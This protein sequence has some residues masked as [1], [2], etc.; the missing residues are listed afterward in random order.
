M[1]DLIRYFINLFIS[2]EGVVG[3]ARL[4]STTANSKDEK[5]TEVRP[6]SKQKATY[7]INYEMTASRQSG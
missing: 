7:L 5:F 3:F 4:K 2:L 1:F 6:I